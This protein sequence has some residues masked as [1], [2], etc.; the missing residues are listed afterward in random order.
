MISPSW[1]LS[2]ASLLGSG[3]LGHN[4]LAAGYNAL[5]LLVDLNNLQLEVLANKVGNLFHIALGQLGRGYE[6]AHAFHISD[7]AALDSLLANAVD[8]LACLVLGHQRIPSLAV[9]DVALE[10]AAHCP[11]RR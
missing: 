4:R 3:F 8:I 6:S 11:R 2:Q 9:D 10:T 7:Q 5:L 1:S